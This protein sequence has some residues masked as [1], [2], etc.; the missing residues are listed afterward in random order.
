VY[1]RKDSFYRRAKSAG[2]RSRAAYKLIELDRRFGFLRAG[3]RVVDLGAWPGGWLQVAAQRVGARGVVVGVDLTPIAPLPPPVICVTGDLRSPET[4]AKILER[5]G[6]QADVVLSDMAPKLSGVRVADQARADELVACALDAA[7][8][9]LRPGG[10]FLQK[11]FHNQGTAAWIARLGQHFESVKATRPEA[12]RAGSAELYV[13]AI[14]LR[15]SIS[16]TIR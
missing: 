13:I 4:L 1:Q 11:L 5:C 16:K 15:P 8:A 7:L 6:H 3:D 10:R 12:T 9:L 14:G 2:Y